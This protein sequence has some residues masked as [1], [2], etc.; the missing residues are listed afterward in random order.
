MADTAD[1]TISIVSHNHGSLVRLLLADLNRLESRRRATVL[2]TLNVAG[3]EIDLR[4]FDQL[5]IRVIRNAAPKGF[6]ANHNQAFRLCSTEWFAV[7]NP[8]VR[9]PDDSF[10]SMLDTADQDPRIALVAP[11]VVDGD[12]RVEDSVR[13]NLSPLSLLRRVLF[14]TGA[15][16]SEAQAPLARGFRWYAGMFLLF[17]AAAFRAVGGFDERFF[18]YCED[19]DI[20]ARMHLAR[21]SLK[22]D[23]NARVVHMAR[24]DSHQSFRHLRW[25]VQSLLRVWFSKPVWSI[26]LRRGSRN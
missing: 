25:H 14:R 13:A 5:S 6:G 16:H 11:I 7:V 26:A 8:D 20:C 9:M 19:Y 24:R 23:R 4:E 2:L 17:R 21:H 22:L 10:L 15:P 18:L 12:G 1:L 3:E